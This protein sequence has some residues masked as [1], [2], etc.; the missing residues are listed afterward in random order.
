MWSEINLDLYKG[1]RCF[2]ERVREKEVEN[3]GLSRVREVE[4]YR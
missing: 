4:N 2:K 3:Q 1:D